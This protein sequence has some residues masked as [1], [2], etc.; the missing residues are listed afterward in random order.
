MPVRALT[1]DDPIDQP[2]NVPGIGRVMFDPSIP[3]SQRG[4]IETRLG[5]KGVTGRVREMSPDDPID[6]PYQ[7]IGK[8]Y[9]VE[10]AVI[11]C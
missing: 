1:A 11:Y 7:P 6:T 3:T 8:E 2:T 5:I 4:E 9:P 10:Y